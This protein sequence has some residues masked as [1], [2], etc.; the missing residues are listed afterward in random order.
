MDFWGPIYRRGLIVILVLAFIHAILFLLPKYEHL[1]E[2]H[3]KKTVMEEE[4]R[5][6]EAQ[7]AELRSKRERFGSDPEF[8]ERVARENEF[9]KPDETVFKFT[10]APPAEHRTS[11]DQTTKT[12]GT[13]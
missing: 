2:L 4:N 11:K 6:I 9:V 3:R 13:K 12:R 8:V 5:Q 1:R 7:I 10:N